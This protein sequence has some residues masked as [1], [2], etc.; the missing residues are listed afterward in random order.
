[1]GK[2]LSFITFISI[3]YI[4]TFIPFC[5]LYRLSD[6]CYG[7]IYYIIRYRRTTVSQHLTLA[8]PDLSHKQR[9]KIERQFYRNLCDIALETIKGYTA[10]L[11]TLQK[12]WSVANPELLNAFFDNQQ[13]AVIICS[14]FNNWEWGILLEQAI[15]HHCIEFYK[16]L[17]NSLIDR[18]IKKS[19]ARFGVTL[20][21][22]KTASRT[23]IKYRKTPCCYCLISDQNPGQKNNYQWVTFLNQDTAVI[24]G[25]EIIASS[26]NYPVVYMSTYRVKRGVYKVQGHLLTNHSTEESNATIT[27]KAMRQLEKDIKQYPSDW[28]WTHRRWKMKKEPQSTPDKNS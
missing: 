12:R 26:F 3:K 17:H 11:K 8:F 22:S 27:E 15:K 14:H 7:L 16:P 19:R 1:M 25:P 23:L 2:I 5:L 18:S 20:A 24:N 13:S 28:L 10:S 6:L 9:Q 4:V 21:S